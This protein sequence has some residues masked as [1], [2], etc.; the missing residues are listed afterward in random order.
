M[1]FKLFDPDPYRNLI[2]YYLITK[3]T[4]YID[5]LLFFHL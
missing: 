2:G 5:F 3:D 1:P 4:P